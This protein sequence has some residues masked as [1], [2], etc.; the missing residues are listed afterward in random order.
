MRHEW[1]ETH[2]CSCAAVAILCCVCVCV[3]NVH[4]PCCASCHDVLCTQHWPRS[5]TPAG[6]GFDGCSHRA[7]RQ[8]R[9]TSPLRRCRRTRRRGGTEGTSWDGVD[10]G[11]ARRGE[12]GRG[13]N[14]AGPWGEQCERSGRA[15]RP[16]GGRQHTRGTQRRSTPDGW[17]AELRRRP[18]ECAPTPDGAGG[19]AEE[20]ASLQNHHVCQR[21]TRH[22]AAGCQPCAHGG[23]HGRLRVHTRVS[24][25]GEAAG[26]GA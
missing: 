19:G 22:A 24:G 16:P 2:A 1:R 11:E 23:W 26:S 8:S 9:R 6:R 25:G 21:R 14:T 15:V 20:A 12:A 13:G 10:K 3:C 5:P 18:V 7:R 17:A 4:V